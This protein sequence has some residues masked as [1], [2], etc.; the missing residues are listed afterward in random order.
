MEKM[1]IAEVLTQMIQRACLYTP[2]VTTSTTTVTTAT[3]TVTAATTTASRTK[4]KSSA[5][6]K[7]AEIEVEGEKADGEVVMEPVV[8]NAASYSTLVSSHL[9]R[10]N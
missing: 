1:D 5:S 10:L 2:T 8:S 7:T 3:T 4:M 9:L 6:K